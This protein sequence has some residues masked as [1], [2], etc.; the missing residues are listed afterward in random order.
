MN[1]VNNKEIDMKLKM[2]TDQIRL[3][4]RKLSK[5]KSLNLVDVKDYFVIEYNTNSFI[6][7]HYSYSEFIDKIITINGLTENHQKF[8]HCDPGYVNCFPDHPSTVKVVHVANSE[9]L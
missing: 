9:D 7:E 2:I 1:T 6:R 5:S 4:F 3:D 8:I